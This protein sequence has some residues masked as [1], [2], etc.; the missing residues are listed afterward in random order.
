MT[1]DDNDNEGP[2]PQKWEKPMIEL[3]ITDSPRPTPKDKNA[4]KTPWY[5]SERANGNSFV[6]ETYIMAVINPLEQSEN[7]KGSNQSNSNKID[8]NAGN[9]YPDIDFD[10]EDLEWD[11][12]LVTSGILGDSELQALGLM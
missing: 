5:G 10:G 3:P 9:D 8:Q 2:K 12:G 1:Q 11:D 4:P 7:K 6:A